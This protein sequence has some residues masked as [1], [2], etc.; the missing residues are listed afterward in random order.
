MEIAPPIAICA[1][2]NC[3]CGSELVTIGWGFDRVAQAELP[4][5]QHATAGQCARARERSARF[6]SGAK[7]VEQAA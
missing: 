4:V 5:F 6:W 3:Q 2:C 1:I 7:A